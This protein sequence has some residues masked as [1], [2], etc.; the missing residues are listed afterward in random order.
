MTQPCDQLLFVEGLS[1]SFR[2]G[3]TWR[4]VVN[5]LSFTLAGTET[6]AIVGE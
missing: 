6:L 3:G 1:V 5:D 4:A 2:S